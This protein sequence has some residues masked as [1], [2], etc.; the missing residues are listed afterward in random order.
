MEYSFKSVIIQEGFA[1]LL[2]AKRGGYG[3]SLKPLIFL[4]QMPAPPNVLTAPVIVYFCRECP[5]NFLRELSIPQG[6]KSPLV[7]ILKLYMGLSGNT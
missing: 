1:Y 6:Q 3:P 2:I 4:G 7:F 5:A